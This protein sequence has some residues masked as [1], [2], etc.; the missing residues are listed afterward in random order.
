MAIEHIERQRIVKRRSRP[1]HVIAVHRRW[2][3][4]GKPISPQALVANVAQVVSGSRAV[5]N[6]HAAPF[7]KG[8]LI[9]DR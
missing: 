4:E 8:D 9:G 7:E 3:L 5:G 2:L 1:E 6:H